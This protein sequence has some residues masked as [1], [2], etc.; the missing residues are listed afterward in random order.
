MRLPLSGDLDASN[1][2]ALW[3]RHRDV[4]ALEVIDLSAVKRIDSA[5][6]A[7]V[8][9]LQARSLAAGQAP[10]LEHLPDHFSRL[11]DAHRLQ[12][13]EDTHD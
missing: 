11:Q 2:P 13:V 9:V 7:F 10:R 5:G 8:R 3:R 12:P 4:G 1:V 6:V